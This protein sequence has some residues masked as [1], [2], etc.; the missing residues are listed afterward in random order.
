MPM[1]AHTC[2]TIDSWGGSWFLHQLE[3]DLGLAELQRWL[4]ADPVLSTTPTALSPT[5]R[6]CSVRRQPGGGGR[7]GRGS[8]GQPSGAGHQ[9]RLSGRWAPWGRSC[10]TLPQALLTG[11]SSLAP[12]LSRPWP[13]HPSSHVTHLAHTPAPPAGSPALQDLDALLSPSFLP[14]PLGAAVP[15]ADTRCVRAIFVSLHS[16]LLPKD[17][18]CLTD[19]L[20]PLADPAE[21][22]GPGGFPTLFVEGTVTRAL[23]QCEDFT[24]CKHATRSRHHLPL[25]LRVLRLA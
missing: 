15:A 8:E 16:A 24:V 12:D 9:Q 23:H 11:P 1:S 2:C 13:G 20:H 6:A 19:P 5:P 22:R 14:A 18:V 21:S 7:G 4:G 3:F 10:P 25:L 17:G